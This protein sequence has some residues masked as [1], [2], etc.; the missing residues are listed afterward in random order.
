M[1]V[2]KKWLFDELPNNKLPLAERLK[3]ETREAHKKAENH[4][5]FKKLINK[6]L[7]TQEYQSH[8]WDLYHVYSTLEQ[9][10][11]LNSEK[12]GTL[13]FPELERTDYLKKDLDTDHFKGM[14]QSTSEQAMTYAEHLHRLGQTDPSL[15]IAH[16]YVRY[17]G[18]LSG[19]MIIKK[20]IDSQWPGAV[21]FYDF[22]ALFSNYNN[23]N[24]TGFKEFYKDRLNS[25]FF[26]DKKKDQLIAEANKA[27]ELS[28]KLFDAALKK[29]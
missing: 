12:F 21:N 27:F 1:M 15:L 13:Y 25:L 7:T 9:E 5:F 6:T 18:D 17:L 4:S 16:A 20:I 2:I 11:K 19:G 3:T 8:L 26:D 10:I 23:T 24:A 29:S 14:I 22:S 28:E